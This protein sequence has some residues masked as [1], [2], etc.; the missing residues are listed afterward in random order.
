MESIVSVD[1]QENYSKYIKWDKEELKDLVRKAKVYNILDLSE[2][3]SATPIFDFL[4]K[5]KTYF[6]HYDYFFYDT[7]YDERFTIN[8]TI[9]KDKDKEVFLKNPDKI[10][11]VGVEEMKT[12]Y[13][14][15]YVSS[16]LH[17]F[18]CITPSLKKLIHDIPDKVTLIG[19]AMKECLNDIYEMLVFYKKDVTIN[20]NFVY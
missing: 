8:G 3:R 11:K 14:V 15:M 12:I 4:D 7:L 10:F 19:G 2:S 6:K 5:G 1:V 9:R 18:T 13:D 17:K 20:Y 16:S